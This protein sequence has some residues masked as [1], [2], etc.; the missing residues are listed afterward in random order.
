MFLLYIM[1][2]QSTITSMQEFFNDDT[3]FLWGNSYEN[4]FG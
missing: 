3:S 2:Y 4:R 1:P